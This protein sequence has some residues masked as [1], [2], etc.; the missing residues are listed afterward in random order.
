VSDYRVFVVDP[1][2]HVMGP[3]NVISCE[4]HEEALAEARHYL[5]GNSIE[6]WHG[7]TCVGRLDS[8]ADRRKI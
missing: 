6:I 1:D 3:S 5:N 7:A 4:T 2:G 8:E